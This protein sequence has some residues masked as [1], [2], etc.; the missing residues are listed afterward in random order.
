MAKKKAVVCAIAPCVHCGVILHKTLE[1]Q[2]CDQCESHMSVSEIK[3]GTCLRCR[4]GENDEYNARRAGSA[5]RQR[6]SLAKIEAEYGPFELPFK[7]EVVLA[8][9]RWCASDAYKRCFNVVAPVVSPTREKID[10]Q[11]I[12]DFAGL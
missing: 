8:Y 3:D 12:D 9:N 6:E 5:D 11:W 10:A 1:I 4:S 2:W 7:S